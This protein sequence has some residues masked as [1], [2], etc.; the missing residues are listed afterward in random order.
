[1][2]RNIPGMI[3]IHQYPESR[4]FSESESMLPHDMISIGRPI[5]IKLKVDSATIALLTFMTTMN[6][7]DEKKFGAR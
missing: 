1:M 2:I 3:I 6:I 5:P 7:I 4:A